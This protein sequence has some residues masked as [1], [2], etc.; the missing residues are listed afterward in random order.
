MALL[1]T[2]H[3]FPRTWSV[4]KLPEPIAGTPAA[5]LVFGSQ[6]D[7]TSEVM[8]FYEAFSDKWEE[9]FPAGQDINPAPNHLSSVAREVLGYCTT[10]QL[11]LDEGPSLFHLLNNVV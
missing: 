7:V 9:R 4:Y 2:Y 10:N 11:T 6:E 1:Q 8:K 3:R 5:D